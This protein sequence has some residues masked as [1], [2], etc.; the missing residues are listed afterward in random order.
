MF[1][2]VIHIDSGI[3]GALVEPLGYDARVRYSFEEQW[4]TGRTLAFLAPGTETHI[5]SGIIGMRQNPR[6][7]DARDTVPLAGKMP[8]IRRDK[9]PHT[10]SVHATARGDWQC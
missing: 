9:T 8:H 3:N 5:H 2:T 1:G 4:N 10:I 6:Y 7:C